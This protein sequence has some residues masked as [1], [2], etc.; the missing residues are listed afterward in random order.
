MSGDC[1]V[2]GG[3]QAPVDRPGVEHRDGPIRAAAEPRHDQRCRRGCSTGID[4]AVRRALGS[5]LIVATRRRWP[6]SRDR[7]GTCGATL[8]LPLRATT[9]AVTVEPPVGAPFTI[10]LDLPLGRCP[11]CGCDNLPSALAGAVR[12]AAAVASGAVSDGGISPRRRRGGRGSLGP[13]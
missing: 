5:G 6:R 7:C 13:A 12:R 10:T 2:C 8:D 4:A 11:E 9:R 3:P 1:Q